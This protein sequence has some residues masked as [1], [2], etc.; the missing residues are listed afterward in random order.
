MPTLEDPVSIGGLTLSN[1]LYRAPLLECAGT[2]SET[3]DR[4]VEH[5]EP[6]AAAGAGLVCQGATVVTAEGGCAAPR[7]TRV[8]DG[9]FVDTLGAVPEAIHAHGGRVFAQLAHGGLRSLEAWHTEANRAA[10]DPTQLA[11]S[12]PPAPLRLLDRLGFLHLEP[13]VLD[14]GE[15]GDLAV[16]FGEAAARLVAAGYDG[17][18]IS[19]ANMSLVQ[20]FLSPYYNRRDD[21]FG[22]SL[23]ARTR[24]L[25]LIH[26]EIRARVGD[27]PLVTKVPCETAAPPFARPRID[28]G[29]AIRIAERLA[30]YGFD[31]VVPVR[32]S[33]FWDASIVRGRYP[34]EAWADE[35]FSEGYEAAFGGALRA[36]MVAALTRLDLTR[37]GFE[38]AWNMDLCR[39][40]RDVV[41]VPVL[42]EGGVRSRS[43]VDDILGANGPTAADLVGLGRPFYAEPRLPALLL[44]TAE[45]R[46]ACRSCNNCAIPQVSGAEGV[47]RTPDVLAERGRRERE[48][49]Y[50][51]PQ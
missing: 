14:T 33:T 50:D 24:F 5:L 49:V 51:P 4:L 39:A 29:T 32:C 26:D 8:H 10:S 16:A 22:G 6:A 27:V 34:A 23:R 21:E 42:C 7:M 38:R 46:V 28:K 44:D 48:G 17:I 47:C 11:A 30:A 35:R 41:D 18:H 40:V 45:G 12:R 36:K 31:A 15:V 20:Q 2:D 43:D 19:A 9:E 3:A 37:V 13:K 25:E 1:R